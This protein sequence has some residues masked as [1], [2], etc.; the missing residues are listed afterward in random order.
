MKNAEKYRI[1]VVFTSV[2]VFEFRAEMLYICTTEVEIVL[3]VGVIST[4][5]VHKVTCWE[6]KISIIVFTR[7]L[8]G[9]T[10]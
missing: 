1:I 7:L 3:N 5:F 2:N 8:I 6:Q 4:Y 10:M 9:A